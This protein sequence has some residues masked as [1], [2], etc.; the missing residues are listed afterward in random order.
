M[1]FF[2]MSEWECEQRQKYYNER[3]VTV[4]VRAREGKRIGVLEFR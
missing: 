1:G 4:L 2:E 3:G